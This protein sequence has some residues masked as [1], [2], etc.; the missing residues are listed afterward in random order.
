M[1]DRVSF[2]L[3]AFPPSDPRTVPEVRQLLDAEEQRLVS[4]TGD[5]LPPFGEG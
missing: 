1:K 4:S 3:Q 2:D 5:A